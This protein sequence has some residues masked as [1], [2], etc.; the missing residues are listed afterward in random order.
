MRVKLYVNGPQ[1]RTCNVKHESE[2]PATSK[3]HISDHVLLA[4]NTLD[5]SRPPLHFTQV[6]A[7]L[8]SIASYLRTKSLPP[9]LNRQPSLLLLRACDVASVTPI[10]GIRRMSDSSN[11]I[12]ST[13]SL[14]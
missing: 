1:R 13:I 7:P 12:Q 4:H 8:G 5:V 10:A 3:E 2:E 14:P 11:D 6:I 9:A